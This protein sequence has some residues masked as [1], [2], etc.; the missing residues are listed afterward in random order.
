RRQRFP[1]F[2][3]QP[4]AQSAQQNESAKPPDNVI[5]L[6]GAQESAHPPEMKSGIKYSRLTIVIDCPGRLSPRLFAAREEAVAEFTQLSEARELAVVSEAF[7]AAK[8]RALVVH[9]V[10]VVLV[11]IAAVRLGRLVGIIAPGE[12]SCQAAAHHPSR[13]LDEAQTEHNQHD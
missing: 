3:L 10:L 13:R 8:F 9:E 6:K 11:V 4:E 2:V 5:C 12:A 1:L 7:Y